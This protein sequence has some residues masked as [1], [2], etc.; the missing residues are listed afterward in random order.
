MGVQN[1]EGT[2]R[3][4]DFRDTFLDAAHVPEAF[5]DHTV[6]FVDGSGAEV[7]EAERPPPPYTVTFPPFSAEHASEPLPEG[8]GDPPAGTLIVRSYMPTVSTPFPQLQP[9]Q[10]G[11]RFNKEQLQVILA[12]LQ[13]GLTMCVGPPGTGKTDTAVQVR[14]PSA[15]CRK[16]HVAEAAVQAADRGE[17]G[18]TACM[19]CAACAGMVAVVRASWFCV[20]RC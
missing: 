16:A 8:V 19:S 4:V 9:G 12:G 6:K 11:V 18:S 10:N 2:V 17:P 13:P 14:R 5:P 15:S 3:H 20:C 1:L 7:P